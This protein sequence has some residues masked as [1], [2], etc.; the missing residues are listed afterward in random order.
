[1]ELYLKYH[2][3][4]FLTKD[5]VK[6]NKFDL[7]YAQLHDKNYILLYFDNMYCR[8]KTF[9]SKILQPLQNSRRQDVR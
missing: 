5:R 8:G 7:N 3:V 6:F 1:V 2:V 9:F 4:K